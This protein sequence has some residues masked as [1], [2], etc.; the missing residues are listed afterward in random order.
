M[1]DG[2]CS[3]A[4]ETNL[5]FSE[6]LNESVLWYFNLLAYIKKKLDMKIEAQKRALHKTH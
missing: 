4:Q 5:K 2:I 3:V 6:V 1:I